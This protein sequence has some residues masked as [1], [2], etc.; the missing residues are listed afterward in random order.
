MEILPCSHVGHL[1]RISTYSFDGNADEIRARNNIR[2]IDVWMPEFRNIF[3]AVSPS[4]ILVSIYQS[5]V[6]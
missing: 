2:L 4:N 3:Y 1:Y 5:L 6:D